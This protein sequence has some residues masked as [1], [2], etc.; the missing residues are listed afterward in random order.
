MYKIVGLEISFPG[1]QRIQRGWGSTY[2]VPYKDVTDDE[3]FDLKSMEELG[4]DAVISNEIVISGQPRN[5]KGWN[6][7]TASNIII[8]PG[9]TSTMTARDEVNLFTDFEAQNGSEVHIFNS[10]T[11]PDCSDFT[12]YQKQSIPIASVDSSE[13]IQIDFSSIN[14]TFDFN[15][16]PNP[17]SGIFHLTLEN[18][19][20]MN[21]KP[22]LKIYNLIGN[23]IYE[24][25]LPDLMNDFDLTIFAKSMYYVQVIH[26]NNSRVKK[27]IL[28]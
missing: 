18:V 24:K 10:E 28:Q 4:Y 8:E 20:Y 15:L 6:S 1:Y 7:L 12:L 19:Q 2:T 5:F 17:N 3:V 13:E 26:D 27:L 16:Y 14:T 21:S 11:F 22:I 9:G 25:S 23:I